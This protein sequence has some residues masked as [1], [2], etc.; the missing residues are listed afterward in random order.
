[1]KFRAE[2]EGEFEADSQRQ[3]ESEAERA[4]GTLRERLTTGDVV[5]VVPRRTDDAENTRQSRAE[6][7]FATALIATLEARDRATAAHSTEVAALAR[8]IAAQLGLSDKEQSDAEVAGLLHDVGKIGLPPGLIEKT[9][10]LTVGE[11]RQMQEHAAIGERILVKVEDYAEIAKIIRHHHEHWDGTGYPDGLRGEDSPLLARIVAVASAFNNLTRDR[12][13]GAPRTREAALHELLRGAG[14]LFDPDVVAALNQLG[15]AEKNH[16]TIGALVRSMEAKDYYLG[17]H[18][19]RV[20]E[21]AVALAKR[22]GFAGEQLDAIR[23]G[24]L[25]HDIGKT[26]IPDR[27]L[28]KPGP[29]DDE[30]WKVMNEHPVIAEYIL[31]E[32]DLDPIVVQ[33]ARSHHERWDGQGYPDGLAGEGIPLAARILAVANAFDNLTHDRPYRNAGTPEAAL[34]ELRAHSGTQFD[35]LVVVALDDLSRTS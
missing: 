26:G 17:G 34:D 33:V 10:P 18:S 19:E 8:R 7:T 29:L 2:F 22:F 5:A 4:A 24:A 1:M 6:L 27:L 11:Q 21:I 15:C 23:I 3:A 25:L 32:A 20:S 16:N 13:R 12:P 9:S 35:P 31:V 14:T 28:H 30:E